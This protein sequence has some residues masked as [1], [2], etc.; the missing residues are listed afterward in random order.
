MLA[1]QF[2]RGITYAAMC[3]DCDII[4]YEQ[5]HSLPFGM[6]PLYVLLLIPMQKKRIVTVH[7]LGALGRFRFFNY[8]YRKADRIIVHSNDMKKTMLSFG[9]PDS[10]I[11][12]VPHGASLPPLRW[13][14]R[15]E[16]TFFGAPG[17]A[18]GFLTI[19]QALKLLK[20][21]G[22][23]VHLHIYGIYGEE[24]KDEAVVEATRVGVADLLVW[25]G[26]LSEAEFDRKMQESIFTLAP[27]SIVTS[28]S[29]VVTR[30]MGNA[31]PIIASTLGGIPEY[32][33]E[34][35]LLV[36]PDDPEALVSAMTKL[37]D[38]PTLRKKLSEEERKRAETFSWSAVAKKTYDI[39]YQCMRER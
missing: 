18:K 26:R 8:A 2:L 24:E 33:G 7:R 17:K 21:R 25:G 14:P 38:D 19:L 37:L 16:I 9:V 27:Y 29:S 3:K 23:E 5:T 10:K 22:R 1:L 32:L 30:A 4:H 35:G 11:R 15:G 31:T 20:D 34:G 39:Y 6:A 28:G 13:K 12:L 36:P